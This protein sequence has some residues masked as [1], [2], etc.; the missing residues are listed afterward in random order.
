MFSIVSILCMEINVNCKL[1]ANNNTDIEPFSICLSLLLFFY[2]AEIFTLSSNPFNWSPFAA[3]WTCN[4]IK[5]RREVWVKKKIEHFNTHFNQQW[6]HVFY[7][8]EAILFKG[9]RY[10]EQ[11]K[12]LNNNNK[13]GWTAHTYRKTEES[14]HIPFY[15]C[16][17][18][19]QECV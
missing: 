12:P 4:E 1:W 5:T 2:I 3:Y 19:E 16:I 8:S 15:L 6:K 14:M 17:V 9:H 13:A 10:R 11:Q 7:G 18:S